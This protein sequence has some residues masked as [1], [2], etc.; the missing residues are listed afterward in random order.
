MRKHS[1]QNRS[2][3]SVVQLAVLKPGE[4]CELSSGHLR[5]GT[6]RD[7]RFAAAGV[8]SDLVGLLTTNVE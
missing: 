3:L 1:A 2:W 6:H 7:R 8:L 5:D 4:K